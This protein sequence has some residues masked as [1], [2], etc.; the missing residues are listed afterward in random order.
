MSDEFFHE[1]DKQIRNAWH[2][3]TGRNRRSMIIGHL[4]WQLKRTGSFGPYP[5]EASYR[6]AVG[7]SRAVW[8]RMVR[9]ASLFDKL[10]INR[11]I[12]MTAANAELLA[13]LPE[14][15]RYEPLWLENAV[16]LKE[17][18]FRR[19]II[20]EKANAAGIPVPEMR[21]TYKVKVFEGQRTVITEAVEEFR[22]ESEITDPG[23]ALEWMAM[24]YTSRKT[25]VQFIRQQLPLLRAALKDGDSKTA[26]A[27]HVLA[28]AELVENLKGDRT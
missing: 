2:I 8:G 21:V 22:R 12:L 13:Q 3:E 20:A 19:L 4:G 7:V 18:D 11:F 27:E 26:L 14:K 16:K 25:F 28:L 10:D 17:E 1:A 15:K 6:D 9:L 5:D 23:T 24:E